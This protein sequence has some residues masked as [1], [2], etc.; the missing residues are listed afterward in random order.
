MATHAAAYAFPDGRRG[1]IERIL[2]QRTAVFRTEDGALVTLELDA[3][4][5]LRTE[6][7]EVR[8]YCETH[9]A[10]TLVCPACAGARGGKAA[11]EAKAAAAR[12]NGRRGGRPKKP[13]VRHT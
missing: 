13:M 10:V 11:T 12:A 6:T 8:P 2:T 5:P 7:L 1:Y 4:R 3:V 9:P